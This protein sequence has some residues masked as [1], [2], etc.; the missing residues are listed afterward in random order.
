MTL[1]M[2]LVLRWQRVVFVGHGFGGGR[3]RA[4]NDAI[5]AMVH[6]EMG[7]LMST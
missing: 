5:L 3:L 7:H 2:T 1:D 6:V 4:I